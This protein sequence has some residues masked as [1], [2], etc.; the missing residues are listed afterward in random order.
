MLRRPLRFFALLVVLSVV[1]YVP[2]TL[3]YGSF[4]WVQIWP[5]QIQ[6]NRVLLYLVYFLS[7]V[8]L[9]AQGIGR[10]LLAPNSGLSRRWVAWAVAEKAQRRRTAC[11]RP[12]R[13]RR[14]RAPR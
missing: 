3:A 9:G 14:C 10:T 2:L 4:T 11:P 6:V 12:S 1:A 13:A 7:G 8:V 5:A